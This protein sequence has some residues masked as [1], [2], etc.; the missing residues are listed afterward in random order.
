MSVNLANKFCSACG[1]ALVETAVICPKCGSPTPKFS[2]KTKSPKSKT[3]A[4]LLAAFLGAWSWLYTYKKNKNKFWFSVGLVTALSLI[5]FTWAAV[6][7][8]GDYVSDVEFEVRR[9]FA[10]AWLLSPAAV[11]IWAIVDNSLKKPE[12]YENYFEN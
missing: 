3:S 10:W 2:S 5:I 12:W 11:W 4:V 8:M 6:A 9:V 7:S 1:A